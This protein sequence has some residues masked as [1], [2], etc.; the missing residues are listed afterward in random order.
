MGDW[1]V[2]GR[3]VSLGATFCLVVGCLVFLGAT[4]SSAASTT[5]YVDSTATC[6]GAG[7][8]ASPWCGFS[9][10][11]SSTFQPGD[12]ILLKRGDSFT[13]EMVLYGSGTSTNYLTVSAYGSG[14][15]PIINGNDN[16]SFIGINLYNNS[17]VEIEDITVED[18]GTGILINDSTNQTGYRFLDLVLSGDG[19]GIQSPTGTGTASN[20]LVQDVLGGANTLSC[21]NNGPCSGATLALAG[22]SDVIVNRLYSY[23][24]CAETGWGPGPGASNVIIENSESIGDAAC[25]TPGGSTANYI[26]DDTNLTFVND[27]IDDVPPAAEVDLSALDIEPS[28]GPDSG[29]NIEDNYIANNAGPGIEVLDHPAPITNLNISGN[30]FSDNGAGYRLG[31]VPYP[32]WGQI[33]TSEWLSN[34]VEAT[35]SIEN[36]LYNAPTGTGGFEVAN[37]ANFSGFD[38]NNNV[39]ASGPNNLW[40]AA[41]GF[42]CSTQGANG[43]SYQSSANNSTWTNL[44]GCTTLATLDQE[45]TTGGTASGFVSNFEE[46]P[47]S[48][49]TSWVARS[50]TAPNAGSASIRGRVLMTDPTCASGVTAEI[51]KNGSSTPLWGPQTI[52][53]GNDVGVDANLDGVSVNAGDV[54]HFAVQENGS[55][56][57]RVSWTPS[58]AFPNPV[59][60]VTAPSGG[61]D[62]AGIQTL[63][64]SASDSASPVS[65]VQY[66]L[67]GGTLSDAVIATGSQTQNGWVASWQSGTV[68]NGAY[69]L[70]S[71]VTDAAG[72]VAYSQ[73]VTVNVQNTVTTNV[74]VPSTSGSW[75]S[76]SQVVLDAGASDPAGVNKVQFTL[77]G[78]SLNNAVVATATPSRYGWIAE[79]NSTE[80]PDG[81]YTLQSVAS[82][83]AGNQGTSPGVT[84]IVENTPPKP[85]VAIPSNGSWVS[86]EVFL[87]AGVATNVGVTNV[88]FT[89]TGGSLDNAVIAQAGPSRYGWLGAWDT[90]TVPD[91]TYTLQA[92]ASDGAGFEG[93]SK[94][95]TVVVENTSPTTSIVLPSNGASVSGSQVVLDAGATLNVGVNK[96][97]FTLTGGS[98]DNA[99][100][101]TA[102]ASPYGWIALWNST[103]VPNGT[104]TLGSE[105]SDGAGF[106]GV[107]PGVTVVVDN[108]PPTTSIVV[109]SNGASVSGSQVGLDASASLN[110][111][112]NQVQ[113]TLTGGSLDNAVIAT[114]TPSYYGWVATWNST[115][116]PDGTYTLESEASDTAG[117]QGVSPGVTVV[118]DNPPPTTSIVIPSN[119]ASVS[120]AQVLLDAGASDSVAGVSSVGFYLTGGSL[121]DVLIATA[122]PSYYGWIA[123]WNSATVPDGTY[124][125]QSEASDPGGD[126]GVSP[127][128]SVTV[129]N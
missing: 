11:D 68:P 59:T 88:E 35:G 114:A 83:A 26:D 2:L 90:T 12:Q 14:A 53:A 92:E 1:R 40:Y 47:P 38:Q 34:F 64:A 125:L 9:V 54:L 31:Y 118:V 56:Q 94:G 33:W 50:W 103:T 82:D 37:G 46:L 6:P 99:L 5:Y 19:E 23:G 96:V 7:T 117:L 42:S 8:E 93:V 112:V 122:T 20:V 51:T 3:M 113:F 58:V 36:N 24:G 120:G 17:Y 49:S 65:Q 102:T 95:V 4:A 84:V 48:T 104:Y 85:T 61:S 28:D 86:G 121:N 66:V 74:L 69:T 98:L 75:V 73:G 63:D 89:L 128:I 43:W 16:T 109:P 105:A 57:C 52:T 111:G 62:L 126:Q 127:A 116:V 18:A 44:S 30:V 45:W 15:A 129:A 110:M 10:I 87:G 115:T 67:T 97:Q 41:N 106:E 32:V 70:Q 29:I 77:T 60:T 71:V 108:P 80:V 21:S 91:G 79:W 55:S 124:T 27:V 81:T 25:D 100:I 72:N 101:A 76:G 107:S 13:G 123:S 119:G 39:A 22:V 78:G